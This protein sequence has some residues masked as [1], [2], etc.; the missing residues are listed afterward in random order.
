MQPK[1]DFCDTALQKNEHGSKNF[2]ILP[3]VKAHINISK[4]VLILRRF[5]NICASV[6]FISP[7]KN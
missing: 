7:R 6:W 2:Q 1:H 3:K 5:C 4:N